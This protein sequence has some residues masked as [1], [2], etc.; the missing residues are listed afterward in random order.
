[1][2]QFENWLKNIL[3]KVLLIFNSSKNIKNQ[4]VFNSDSNLLFI[5]LNRIGDALVTTPL[6]YQIKQQI[7]CKIFVL[8]DKKNYFVFSNNPSIDEV[9]IFEKGIK[10]FLQ[11]KNIIS[12]KSIDAV[13]DLHDDVSTTVSFLIAL[14][15]VK[16]KLGLRKS[17]SS[18][19]TQTVKR[20]DSRTN[21]VIDRILQ[22]GLLFNLKFERKSIAI[23]YIPSKEERIIAAERIKFMNPNKK[24]LIG[25][26]ISAGSEARFWGVDNYIKLSELL[27]NYDARVIFF[28]S[29]NE[30]NFA[31]EITDEINIY[32]LTE[33]FGIFASAIMQLDFLITPDTSVVHIASINKIPVFGLYVKYNTEDMIWSP[34]NTDFECV[35]TEEPTLKNISFD[36]V[37]NK[38]I[39]FLEKHLNVKSNSSL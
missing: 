28:T 23:N 31:K 9:V 18:I 38:L 2:K 27:S 29:K 22:I 33:A 15:N 21:H 36:E 20:L 8:A 17:N 13:V 3:L 7:G 32:P 6:L 5:R 25:V 4:P 14:A 11:I 1:M 10:G 37:K 35:V 12:E 30:S 39:P 16:Y 26:N 19:Y 24:F 34:Y